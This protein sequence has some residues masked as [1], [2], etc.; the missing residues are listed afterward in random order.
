MKTINSFSKIKFIAPVCLTIAAIFIIVSNDRIAIWHPKPHNE[1][2]RVEIAGRVFKIPKGYFDGAK[3]IGR[4]N[5]SVVLEYSLP[6]FEFLPPHPQNRAERQKLISEGRMRGMLLENAHKLYTGKDR[7]SFDVVVP[8]LMRAHEFKKDK[9]TIYGLE[10]YVH[11][12]PKPVSDDPAYAPYVQDDF[13]IERNSDGTIKS[14][15][16][17][18]PFGKD[19]VPG[20]IQRF[21]DKNILYDIDWRI[22]ELPNWQAQRDAAIQFIDGLEQSASTK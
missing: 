3:A 11:Q 18:S 1:A 12:V 2:F 7:P 17:C 15:L 13:F 19:K 20:C 22:Q 9:N 4:D 10:K 6:G 21:I 16:M 14:Y 8:N 5:E